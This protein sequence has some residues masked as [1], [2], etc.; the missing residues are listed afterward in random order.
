MPGTIPAA[1]K[2]PVDPRALWAAKLFEQV[3]N[4]PEME[5]ETAA[6]HALRAYTAAQAVFRRAERYPG[7]GLVYANPQHGKGISDLYQ[8]GSLDSGGTVLKL[9]AKAF[10]E[11]TNS[12]HAMSGY[13]FV[14]ITGDAG[15]GPYDYSK[16]FGLCAVPVR[17]D[18]RRGPRPAT[19]VV[20]ADG[21]Y[22]KADTGGK[23]VTIFPDVTKGMWLKIGG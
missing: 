3:H 8:L 23:A 16:Q 11:A 6:I 13:Y 12:E 21:R 14:D 20:D 1:R 10:A 2:T 9:I 4:P 18:L 7:K 19:L 22:Y 5:N 15:T 17:Y